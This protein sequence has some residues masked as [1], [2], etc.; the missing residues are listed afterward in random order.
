MAQIKFSEKTR[1]RW[2][3]VKETDREILML[4]FSYQTMKYA[5][6]IRSVAYF[7]FVLAFLGVIV[8]L[9]V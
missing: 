1:E 6:D 4:D 5:K 2:A 8:N 3:L 7:F 9:F